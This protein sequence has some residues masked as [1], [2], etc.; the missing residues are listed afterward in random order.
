[1]KCANDGERNSEVFAHVV[2]G[3]SNMEN[4]YWLVIATV[5]LG[6]LIVGSIFLAINVKQ[7]Q[8]EEI[9]LSERPDLGYSGQI[10]I[11]GAVASPGFYPFSRDDTVES[12]TLA[13]GLATNAD[14][15]RVRLYIPRIDETRPVQKVNLNIAEAWL[16]S[17]LPG[18]GQETAQAIVDYRTQHGPFRRI[19]D[20]L[21]IRGIGSSTLNKIK[22]LVT[23]E[24]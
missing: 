16:I 22:G 20:L 4:K 13:A 10:Y 21:R 9:I 3:V 17:A 23:L 1:M 12:L 18:I 11:D 6:S 14:L 8:P 5:L 19:E 15:S 7:H 24:E 2:K